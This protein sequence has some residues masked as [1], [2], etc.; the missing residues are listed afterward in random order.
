MENAGKLKIIDK[1]EPEKRKIDIENLTKFLKHFDHTYMK[2]NG[3]KGPDYLIIDNFVDYFGL[4]EAELKG[5]KHE[6]KAIAN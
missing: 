6:A 5:A 3:P 2:R 1:L 4:D